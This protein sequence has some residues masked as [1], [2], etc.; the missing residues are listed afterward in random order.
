MSLLK[1]WQSLVAV[2][3]NCCGAIPVLTALVFGSRRT[4][5]HFR[6]ALLLTGPTTRDR[7]T[8]KAALAGL[9]LR[10][11]RFARMPSPVDSPR[12]QDVVG[13]RAQRSPFPSVA[14]LVP[15]NTKLTLALT[16]R[17]LSELLS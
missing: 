9:M 4:T 3:G 7:L 11:S 1:A 16:L 5:L 13:E 8:P 6:R 10:A 2:N 17:R 14:R 12:V 15:K